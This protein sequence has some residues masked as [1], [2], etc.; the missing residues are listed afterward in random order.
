M[1]SRRLLLTALVAT[2]ILAA[3][4]GYRFNRQIRQPDLH[5]PLAPSFR[6]P[7]PET[8]RSSDWIACTNTKFRYTIRYPKGWHTAA[9]S[10][11]ETCRWFNPRPF[12][13]GQEIDGPLT[14]VQAYPAEESFEAAIQ[15]LTDPVV[16]R[17]LLHENA[18]V[19]GHRGRAAGDPVDR[20]RTH[21]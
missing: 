8:G 10:P 5:P 9:R 20:R 14:A 21:A 13:V 11:E 6:Y 1:K 4:G 3:V 19:S 17:T 2:A 12:E 7:L 15:G 16:V 18:Q